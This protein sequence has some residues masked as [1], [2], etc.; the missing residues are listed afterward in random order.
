[1]ISYVKIAE[2]DCCQIKINKNICL[3]IYSY[4]IFSRSYILLALNQDNVLEWSDMYVYPQ[5]LVTVS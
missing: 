5:T 4:Y 3:F 1:M 2:L